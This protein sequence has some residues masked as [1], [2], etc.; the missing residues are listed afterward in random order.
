[1][2][3]RKSPNPGELV[4]IPGVGKMIRVASELPGGAV[5][6]EYTWPRSSR[7]LDAPQSSAA[8]PPPRRPRR[9]ASR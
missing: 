8:V 3:P 5:I 1:M 4:S 9:L 7:R 6:V 2:T